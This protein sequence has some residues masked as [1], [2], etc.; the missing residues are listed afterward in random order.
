MSSPVAEVLEAW[1]AAERLLDELPPLDPD[2][3]T[4]RREIVRLRRLYQRLSATQHRS[5]ATMR[6]SAR[7]IER[8][9]ALIATTRDRLAPTELPRVVPLEPQEP[10]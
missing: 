7:M 2:H 8:A 5:A 9:Q 1:R 3:E 6:S 10:F 4:I